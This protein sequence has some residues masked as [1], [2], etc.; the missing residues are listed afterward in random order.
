MDPTAPTIGLEVGKVNDAK[1][2]R[3]EWIK[4]FIIGEIGLVRSVLKRSLYQTAQVMK[5]LLVRILV[6]SALDGIN[7]EFV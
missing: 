5:Q 3:V 7:Q 4:G 1:A 6:D 2:W